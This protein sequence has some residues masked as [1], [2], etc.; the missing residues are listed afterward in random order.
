MRVIYLFLGS[1]VR[2]ES[3]SFALLDVV[4]AL[5]PAETVSAFNS[6]RENQKPSMIIS[7]VESSSGSL[8][9]PVASTTKLRPL[10]VGC[11]RQDY[12]GKREIYTSI[13]F[14]KADKRCPV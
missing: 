10:K 8:T 11:L 6:R 12:D 9:T 13:S 7:F 3:F 5:A 1:F 2:E 14:S 4:M